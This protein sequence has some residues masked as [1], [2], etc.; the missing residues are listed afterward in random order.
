MA[1]CER[2]VYDA[3]PHIEKLDHYFRDGPAVDPGFLPLSHKLEMKGVLALRKPKKPGR[4][5]ITSLI[6]TSFDPPSMLVR[7]SA[8][9]Y[10]L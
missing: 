5:T 9:S 3:G 4:L 2:A 7:F 1:Q 10:S 6:S 8:C